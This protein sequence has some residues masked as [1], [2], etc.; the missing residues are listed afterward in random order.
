MKKDFHKLLIIGFAILLV[1]SL[2]NL[3]YNYGFSDSVNKLTPLIYNSLLT[4]TF[5][6]GL[7]ACLNPK[8]E[9]IWMTIGLSMMTLF[10]ALNLIL[11]TNIITIPLLEELPD[12]TNETMSEVLKWGQN[13]NITINQTYD[14]SDEI[15]EYHIIRQDVKAGTLVSSLQDLTLVVSNGPDPNKEVTISNM[16][17]WNLDQ[18]LVVINNSFLT[19]VTINYEFNNDIAKNIILNQSISGTIKRND[20]V[21]IT[22]SLGNID[23]LTDI[24]MIDLT[25]KS[26]FEASLWLKQNALNF[27][28]NYEFSDTI[29]KNYIIKTDPIVDTTLTPNETVVN[30]TVSLG[31]KIVVPNLLTMTEAD[32]IN[33]VVA[34]KLKITFNETYSNDIKTGDVI[35]ASVNENDEIA[36]GTTINI[37]LSKG[38]LV[39]KPFASLDEFRAWADTNNVNY[40]EQYEFNDEITA[41]QIIAFN[42][43][44]GTAINP[45]DT[46]II[47]ISNGKAITVP[48]FYG[49]TKSQIKAQCNNLGLSCTFYTIDSTKEAGIALKQSKKEGSLV[50]QGA[51]VNIGLSSGTIKDETP[52]CDTSKGTT[53]YLPVPSDEG[54]KTYANAKTQ[55]P[56]YTITVTY[57]TSCNNGDTTPGNICNATTYDAKWISYCTEIKLI[58]VK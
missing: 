15:E 14:Y 22:I 33:W 35:S 2:V 43:E 57:V 41:G 16:I 5:L 24:S 37:T 58:I 4:L 26:L 25:N 55:N 13:H 23:D 17:G 27:N 48:N 30:L 7:L 19:N 34:N 31:H 39:L 36:E 11:K 3:I 32:I 21:I 54:A 49:L 46:L 56:N 20:E 29:K 28:L 51:N 40:T 8:H 12:F 53:F 1:I 45:D 38:K 47:R 18:A 52:T 10:L 42:I 44:V 50:T 6:G 9:A